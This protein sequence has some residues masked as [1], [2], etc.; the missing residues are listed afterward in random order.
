VTVESDACLEE[1]V[2]ADMAEA[3]V[4]A[5]FCPQL[6]NYLSRIRTRPYP[7]LG[8]GHVDALILPLLS[9]GDL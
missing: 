5:L 6:L 3:L 9:V 8:G 1:L 2:R 4:L 7:G